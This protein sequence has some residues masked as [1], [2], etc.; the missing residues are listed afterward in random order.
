MLLLLV[1]KL[2]KLLT[3][4]QHRANMSNHRAM[5]MAI[6]WPIADPAKCELVFEI[7][8]IPIEPYP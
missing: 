4:K 7:T 3:T 6:V 2:W 5:M 1:D 8:R